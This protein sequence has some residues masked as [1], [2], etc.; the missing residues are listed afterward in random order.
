MV[1]QLLGI[2]DLLL[3]VS[4]G[5]TAGLL[6]PQ[7]ASI[8]AVTV[9]PLSVIPTFVVPLCV[10]FHVI[11]IAQARTFKIAREIK[12]QATGLAPQAAAR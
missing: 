4:L 7:G 3:A 8:E 2:T 9:L 10:I 5:T 6:R 11:C 12:R 1:W